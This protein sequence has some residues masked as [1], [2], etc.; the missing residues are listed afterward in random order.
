VTTFVL[1]VAFSIFSGTVASVAKQRT[2]NWENN[3]AANATRRVIES[4]HNE[5]FDQIFLLFN[6]DETDDPGG[7]GTAPGH[8]FDVEGFQALP[9]APGGLAGEI[10]F[11]TVDVGGTVQSP[12]QELRE[13]TANATL[14]TPRDL[15]GDNFIDAQD[16]SGDYVILPV[17][18]RIEWIGK[19]GEREFETSSTLCFYQR[20]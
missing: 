3:R 6:A 2:I 14:G 13:D 20:S 16:H 15:N 10:F 17:R 9:G 11:P 4:M 5:D 19:T 8:R 12:L 7:L 1:L 18:V